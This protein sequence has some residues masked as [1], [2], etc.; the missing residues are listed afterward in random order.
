METAS[1]DSER[2]IRIR[3]RKYHASCKRS[4]ESSFKSIQQIEVDPDDERVR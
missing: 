1:T 4:Q 3:H 2:V